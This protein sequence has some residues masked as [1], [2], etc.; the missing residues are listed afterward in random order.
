MARRS[1]LERSRREL[2][3]DISVG[4]D[5]LVVVEQSSLESQSR[6]CAKTPI[7]AV[8]GENLQTTCLIGISLDYCMNRQ[9]ASSLQYSVIYFLLL[10]TERARTGLLIQ[11][12]ASSSTYTTERIESL[13]GSGRV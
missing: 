5:I 7:L 3:L 13:Q 4:V 8:V 2:S 10:L 1:V 12:P 11:D 6:G 9:H